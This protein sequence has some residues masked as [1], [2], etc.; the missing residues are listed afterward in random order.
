MMGLRD[1][2]PIA[3]S[4]ALQEFIRVSAQNVAPEKYKR[5]LHMPGLKGMLIG[6][7]SHKK[8]RNFEKLVIAS[9]KKTYGPSEFGFR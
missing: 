3:S 7:G 1:V 6:F 2:S 9:G 5:L 8:N 4:P